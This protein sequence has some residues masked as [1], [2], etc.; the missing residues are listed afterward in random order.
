MTEIQKEDRTS[1]TFI[2][3]LKACGEESWTDFYEHYAPLILRFAK[4]RGCS[5]NLAE[6]I[7][8]ET[9][10]A[11]FRCLKDFDY[12]RKK[13]RFRSFLFKIAES[14]IVNAFRKTQREVQ[15]PDEEALTLSDVNK[16]SA[17]SPHQI[18]DQAWEENLLAQAIAAARLRVR[19]MT[20]KCFEMVFLEERAVKDVAKEL[21]ISP[22]LVS[23]H[24]HK[25]Y[26]VIIEE[27][28]KI[29]RAN[30]VPVAP[31]QNRGE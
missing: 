17:V 1:Q 25:V 24:K 10:I 6:D 31:D 11:L 5:D 20:F 3:L 27:A 12:D 15:I 28:E 2:N 14:K 22:N 18:W 30:S 23:Q 8:Q 7:L 26:K 16:Q 19:P 4:K 21:K 29:Q 9:T 13:G